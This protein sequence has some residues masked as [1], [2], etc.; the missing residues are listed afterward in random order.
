MGEVGKSEEDAP[1]DFCNYSWL[2]E[3]GEGD[4]E[5]LAED[6]DDAD[7][8]DPETER[9]GSVVVGRVVA[10]DDACL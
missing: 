8:D 3:T 2:A 1:D 4:C 5:E 10:G 7:L 6:N 9:V